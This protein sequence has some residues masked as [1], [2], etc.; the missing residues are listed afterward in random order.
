MKIRYRNFTRGGDSYPW[1][2]RVSE[3][4]VRKP[5]VLVIWEFIQFVISLVWGGIVI[6]NAGS[7]VQWVQLVIPVGFLISAICLALDNHLYRVLSLLSV[8]STLLWLA[9]QKP[10]AEALALTVVF[11]L[12]LLIFSG[13]M[14]FG[15]KSRAYFAWCRS[16]SSHT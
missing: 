5:K 7:W 15:Q 4:L 8:F 14:F 10:Q 11:G 12:V 13:S 1:A 9:F 16:T 2:T 3:E 6:A